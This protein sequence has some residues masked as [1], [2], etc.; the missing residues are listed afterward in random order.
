MGKVI[1]KCQQQLLS[2]MCASGMVDG[3]LATDWPVFPDASMSI[4]DFVDAPDD[5]VAQF[6]DQR[7][8]KTL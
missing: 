6:M 1:L 7:I 4:F 3:S 8:T 2:A 5:G